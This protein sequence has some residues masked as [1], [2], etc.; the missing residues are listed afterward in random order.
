MINVC[1]QLPSGYGAQYVKTSVPV[2]PKELG[3]VNIWV[4][5]KLT[6][7]YVYSHIFDFDENGKFVSVTIPLI[8]EEQYLSYK[9][10]N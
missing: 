7:F 5:R 1:F 2:L 3:A 9:Y 4:K 10:D 8:D 6:T